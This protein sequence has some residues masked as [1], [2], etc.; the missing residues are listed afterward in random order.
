MGKDPDAIRQE[1]EDTRARIGERVD[2]I[3]YKADVGARVGD[4]IAEKREAVSE[5]VSDIKERLTGAGSPGD[6]EQLRRGA[7]RAAGIAQENPLGLALG[8]VAVG[9]VAGLLLPSTELEDE[10]IGEVADTV[11]DR[12]VETGREALDRGQQVAQEA[13]RRAGEAVD[14]TGQRHLDEMRESTAERAD[15]AV[16]SAR[17]QTRS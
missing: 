12:A 16:E 6:P 11:R 8:A 10:R 13:A 9:F 7:R 5:K 15:D 3:G 1:I 4:T 14:E 17:R 2:A